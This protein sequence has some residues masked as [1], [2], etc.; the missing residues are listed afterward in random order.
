MVRRV[1]RHPGL[2]GVLSVR[3]VLLDVRLLVYV[4]GVIFVAE[5]PDKTALA[6]LLLATRHRPAPV[7]GTIRSPV[8]LSSGFAATFLPCAMS[9]T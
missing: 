7:F 9:E 2:G 8:L 3:S 6:A 4:F 1:P 5:L